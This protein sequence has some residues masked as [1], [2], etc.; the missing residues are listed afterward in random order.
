MRSAATGAAA[1]AALVG[2]LAAV[3]MVTQTLRNSIGVIAPNL[4]AELNL[5][6]AEI[7]LLSSAFFLAFASAQLPLGVALDRFGPKRTM[8]VCAGIVIIGVLL[9]AYATTPTGLIVAR[10]LIGV[11]S[12]CYLMAPLAFYARRFSPERFSTL[13][14]IQLGLGSIGTLLA[15][16]P[17]AFSA[18]TIGWRATF[19]IMAAAMAIAGILVAAVVP[20]DETVPTT[21]EPESLRESVAGIF[22]ALRT[23]S[24]GR[25]F[26]MHLTCYPSFVL[27]VGLWGGPYLT[28]VYGYDLEE[29]GDLLFIAAVGQIAGMMLVGPL[30]RRVG[31]NKIPVLVGAGLT[32][33]ALLMLAILGSLPSWALVTW[34]GVFG[35]ITAFTPLLIAHG[36]ALFPPE[37][38][39]RGMTVLNIGTMAGA[40][41]SQTLTGAVIT[42]FEAP[43]G[44]YPLM[45][46]RVAFALQA[47]CLL[48]S[49]LAY[50]AP[51]KPGRNPDCPVV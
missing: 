12:C 19:L 6:A 40:F 3:Y 33:T 37:L 47:V 25:L 35:V 29:R 20:G 46:Y 51:T 27:I 1:M 8:L 32:V 26:L 2:T 10:A 28:H 18:A 11:G 4:A 49:C 30:E 38:V 42:L 24:V 41:L 22:K 36:K 21:R 7:G 13:A 9:F 14:G 44:V 45:A 39:G 48:L 34:L 5:S 50:R 17:L 31:S 23:P 15:T 43:G 16:A